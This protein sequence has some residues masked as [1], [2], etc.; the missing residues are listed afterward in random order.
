MR[1]LYAKHNKNS[2]ISSSC[3]NNLSIH[4]D[5][6]FFEWLKSDMK[7]KPTD[8]DPSGSKRIE[9]LL[10]KVNWIYFDVVIMSKPLYDIVKKTVLVE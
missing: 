8:E 3:Y 10:Q 6:E 2:C 9:N 7:Q 5:S 1:D 4:F